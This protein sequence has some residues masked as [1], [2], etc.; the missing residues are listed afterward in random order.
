MIPFVDYNFRRGRKVSYFVGSGIGMMQIR[1]DNDNTY[2]SI[3]VVP[4]IVNELFNHLR[5]TIDY[6][7]NEY[8]QYD[9]SGVSISVVLGG[10]VK[11][12]RVKEKGR[13]GIEK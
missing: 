2:S 6:K 5:L 8:S 3:S 12:D 10:G 13:G 7:L 11:K 4:R 9:Y 1:T